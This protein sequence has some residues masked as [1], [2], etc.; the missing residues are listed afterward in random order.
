LLAK[1]GHTEASCFWIDEATGVKRRMRTDRL[2]AGMNLILDLKTG[3]DV[4][5]DG[6][7]RAVA[8]FGYHR[9]AAYYIDGMRAITGEDW[10]MA[11]VGVEKDAPH[12]VAVYVLTDA[13]VEQG[14][15]E[16]AAG[17]V[18]A[19][20]CIESGEWPGYS[21]QVVALDLPRWAQTMPVEI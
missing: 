7:A 9:Q 2:V 15:Q 8:N 12:L 11:F 14:R 6:F 16:N 17:L 4:S 20:R 5:P 18:T 21:D 19:A 10:R 1:G 3:I 13:A